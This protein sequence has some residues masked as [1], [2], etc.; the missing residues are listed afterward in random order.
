MGDKGDKTKEKILEAA[1]ELFSK[2]GF[3]QVT[4]KDI[5]DYTNLSRGGLYRHYTSP[6]Q[7]FE[8]LISNIDRGQNERLQQ[9]MKEEIPAARILDEILSEMEAE[10]NKP[11]DSLSYA[12]YEYAV[13]CGNGYFAEKNR[14]AGEKWKQLLEY[15]I[16]RGEF[17]AVDTEMVTDIIL[18]TYQGI[19]MWS[20]VI[21][22]KGREAGHLVK[23]IKEIL[24][25]E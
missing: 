20:R 11:G 25:A 21:P 19:R 6:R 3:I 4:M 2:K 23:H 22:M 24:G 14:Q 16:A 13:N 10:M 7:I 9:Q 1:L 12:V 8:A 15:G 18:Y 5:C 17:K